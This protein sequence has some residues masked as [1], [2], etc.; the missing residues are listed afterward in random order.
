MAELS[1]KPVV[2]IT[3]KKDI[4]IIV[5]STGD[6]NAVTNATGWGSPNEVRSGLTAIVTS[7]T[8]PGGVVVNV[9]LTGGDFDDDI[10]RA[11][12]ISSSLLLGDGL[13]KLETTFTVGVDSST[14]VTYSFRDV[15][16]K[17]AIGK[18]A[19]GNMTYNDYAEIKLM[20]DKLLQAMEC[21]EY[22]LVEDIHQ[23]ILDALADC[24]GQILSSCGC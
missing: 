6:Y 1:V 5:D 15:A 18:L 13:W 9:T 19:L 3:H 21:E 7:V 8:P 16:L 20:Y 14:V 17:C 4:L 12:N 23:D 22:G 24:P 11:Q 10:K 2:T